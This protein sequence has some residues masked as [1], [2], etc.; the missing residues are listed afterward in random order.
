MQR[1]AF[2]TLSDPTGYVIDDELAREPLRARGWALEM[3]PWDRDGVAWE[4][5]AIVAIRSPWDWVG[6]AD[7]FLGVLEEIDRRGVRLEN[8]LAIVRWNLRKTYL[9]E[10]AARGV[11][12]VPTIF[13]ERLEP[14]GLDALLAELGTREA[15]LKP[16]VGANAEGAFRIAERQ[17]HEVEQYFAD[18]ALMAQPFVRAVLDEGE[19]SLFYFDG[20]YSH[21]VRKRPKAGDFRVQEE[22]GGAIEAVVAGP[23]LRAAGQRTIAALPERPLYA[24][25]DL[26][27]GDA[28]AWW[29]M[30]LELVEPSLY[31]RMDPGAPERFV[32]ALVRRV[33]GE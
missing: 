26:V 2:L 16:V 9:R 30:E 20:V 18:R 14:G 32:D 10:L 6:A 11:A 3:V 1:C 22:H 33:D 17:A 31:L 15:V 5:Y 4:D 23:E 21:A 25:V 29:L 7:A 12:I 8:T 27:R 28:D 24:R 19:Y 13:R